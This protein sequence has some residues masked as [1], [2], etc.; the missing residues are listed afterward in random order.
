MILDFL[1]PSQPERGPG[2]GVTHQ[3]GGAG[4]AAD[5]RRPT[6]DAGPPEPVGFE[7]D[8][9]GTKLSPLQGRVQAGGPATKHQQLHAPSS[10][11][12]SVEHRKRELGEHPPQGVNGGMEE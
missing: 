3:P 5:R 8:D 10:W 4:E 1:A 12:R 7:Q 2:P 9:L 11:S 6:V